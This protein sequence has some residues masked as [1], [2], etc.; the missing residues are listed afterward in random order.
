MNADILRVLV[1]LIHFTVG[2][3]NLKKVPKPR[4][5]GLFHVNVATFSVLWC[6]VRGNSK[7]VYFVNTRSV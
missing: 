7:N 2:R 6:V 4:S 1:V 5:V 3:C